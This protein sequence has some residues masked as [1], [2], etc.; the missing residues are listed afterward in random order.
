MSKYRF[1]NPTGSS[2]RAARHFTDREDARRF[3][4]EAASDFDTISALRKWAYENGMRPRKNRDLL[5]QLSSRLVTGEL[6]ARTSR[7][8]TGLKSALTREKPE[9]IISAKEIL[10]ES[11]IH[12]QRYQQSD[13]D[14]VISAANQLLGVYTKMDKFRKSES[15]YTGWESH[16]IVEKFDLDRLGIAEKF[17][18]KNL[19]LTVLLPKTAHQKR[20][21]SI[22]RS[23]N[24]VKL[25]AS[26]KELLISYRKAYELVGDYCG[27]GSDN[28]QRELMQIVSTTFKIAGVKMS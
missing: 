28:I 18:N 6:V 20:I 4:Q 17:P 12:Y 5:E 10:R 3:L 7:S 9:R 22:L 27:G 21:N 1:G 19:Q 25:S 26:V 8:A 24:P 11:G 23:E 13:S 2:T 15:G 14:I 16:H